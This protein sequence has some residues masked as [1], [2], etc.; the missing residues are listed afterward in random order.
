L[1]RQPRGGGGASDEIRK[2]RY[3]VPVT[4]YPICVTGCQVT[5]AR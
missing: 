3:A 5:G 1:R 2:T 4:R